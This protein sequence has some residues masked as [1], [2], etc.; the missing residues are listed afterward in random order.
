M[1]GRAS[2]L[3][4]AVSSQWKGARE[5]W[6]LSYKGTDPVHKDPNLMT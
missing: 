5:S 3:V 4:L 6:G 1:S 2:F